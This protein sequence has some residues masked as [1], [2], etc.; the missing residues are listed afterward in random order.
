MATQFAKLVLIFSAILSAALA[1]GLFI[2]AL[3]LPEKEIKVT[4]RQTASV[5]KVVQPPEPEMLGTATTS[6]FGS[7]DDRKHNIALGAKQVSS[8]TVPP[9]EEFSF[10]DALGEVTEETGYKKEYVIAY[11]STRKEAGGGIC[12]VSTTM[13]R[14]VVDAGLPI[15]ERRGHGY[16]VGYY[17]PGLDATVYGPWVDLKWLNDTGAP[18]TIKSTVV[19]NEINFS[20]IGMPDGRSA[21]TSE[22]TIN[23]VKPPPLPVY[24]SDFSLELGQ[25]WCPEKPVR[26]MSTE[27]TYSITRADGTVEEQLFETNYK[28]WGKK[29]YMGVKTPAAQ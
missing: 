22:I 29:C 23:N 1:V 5:Q 27:V 12:Q 25:Q 9:G 20:I 17:G 7:S 18:I 16:I 19:G 24:I 10:L 14:A 2:G 26:G 6:F 15:L 11:G 28:P 13:F 21:S 8:I 3:T 4:A